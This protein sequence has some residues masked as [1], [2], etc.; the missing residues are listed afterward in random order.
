MAIRLAPLA[1]ADPAA[2]EIL[3][4]AAF[5]ADR[6]A[7]TAYRIR[8]GMDWLPALSFAALDN[9]AL[10]GTLQSWP[11]AIADAPL[12]LVGPVAVAPGRQGGGVGRAL[13]DRLIAAA[14]KRPM[15]MIGDPE[16]YGRFFGFSAEHTGGWEAPGPVERHRLLALNAEHLPR[17]G[18]LGP[19]AKADAAA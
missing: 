14:G 1:Q 13:M 10:I 8:A 19:F 15:V 18:R 12:T 2:V 9:A 3:L 6:R 11:V 4:D 17:T 7:R 5:G 16:Y